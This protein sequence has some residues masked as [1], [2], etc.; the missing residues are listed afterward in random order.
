MLQTTDLKFSEVT[1]LLRMHLAPGNMLPSHKKEQLGSEGGRE[2]RRNRHLPLHDCEGV[3]EARR[4]HV[5]DEV[6]SQPAHGLQEG[7]QVS[8]GAVQSPAVILRCDVQPV[9]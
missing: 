6:L 9:A 2:P 4:E 1:W 8:Q 7:A 5:S 3:A